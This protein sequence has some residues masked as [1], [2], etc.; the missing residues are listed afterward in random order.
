MS[1][2]VNSPTTL[3]AIGVKHANASPTRGTSRHELNILADTRISLEQQLNR[4]SKDMGKS[5]HSDTTAYMNELYQQYQ[6]IKQKKAFVKLYSMVEQAVGQLLDCQTYEEVGGLN[7]NAK[8]KEMLH[9]LK[10]N[11]LFRYYLVS[12]IESENSLRSLL[13]K[14]LI[15]IQVR[16]RLA[17]GKQWTANRQQQ[18]QARQS[19]AVGKH[20]SVNPLVHKQF[21]A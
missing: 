4:L 10:F 19:L 8:L 1:E 15:D 12:D 2:N 5:S 13:F 20:E 14:Q 9:H 7:L 18:R 21:T 17:I 6:K 3:Q 11:K 16:H